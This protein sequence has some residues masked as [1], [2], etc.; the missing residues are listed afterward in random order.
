MV[1]HLEDWNRF[2]AGFVLIFQFAIGG[3]V[4][5]V[6]TGNFGAALILAFVFGGGLAV[7]AS[8]AKG[9]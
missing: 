9:L 3:I 4:G 1:T 8:I 5:A 6:L 7:V 2:D